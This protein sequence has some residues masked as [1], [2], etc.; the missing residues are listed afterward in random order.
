MNDDNRKKEE[1]NMF[2]FSTFFKAFNPSLWL[3]FFHVSHIYNFKW[4]KLRKAKWSKDEPHLMIRPTTYFLFLS[5]PK[6]HLP[7]IKINGEDLNPIQR[8]LS[9]SPSLP[10]SL[11]LSLSPYHPSSIFF[12]SPHP[13]RAPPSLS[14]SP[15]ISFSIS[16]FNSGIFSHIPLGCYIL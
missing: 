3:Y 7:F 10:L 11:S 15:M 2:Y 14:P 9:L 5:I 16:F 4:D 6:V 1:G 12:F 13:C 8:L